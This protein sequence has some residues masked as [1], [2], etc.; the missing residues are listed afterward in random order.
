MWI[1]ELRYQDPR[2]Q[3]YL[4]SPSIVRLPGG[5]L[6]ASHD[7]F[8]RG[9][10]RNMEGEIHL[11]SVYRSDDDGRTW[12]NVTQISGAFWSTLFTTGDALYLIGATAKRGSVAIRRSE[13][14]GFSW[15][16]PADDKSGLISRAGRY[17]EP[18]NYHCAPV[19]VLE[20]DGRVYRAFEDDGMQDHGRDFLACGVS[21]PVDADLLDASNWTMSNKLKFEHD[22]APQY[23]EKATWLEGNV[24]ADRAGQLWNVLRFNGRRDDMPLANLAAFVRIDEDGA[25]LS[26]DY[27]TGVRELPGGATKFTIR[28]DEG[29]EHYWT[30][31]NDQ[32]A[33]PSRWRRNKLSLYSSPDLAT[34]TQRKLLLA[35]NLE[36]DPE[37][38]LR[39]TGFQ[40]VDWILDP[41]DD[42]TI[43]YL[44]RTAY[45]GA[46]NFH[47]SNR[48][49]F[50]RIRDFRSTLTA[51]R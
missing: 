21:A 1:S 44:S 49:T 42:G 32:R 47:D 20:H 10:P 28:W 14:G 29:S 38:S 13:D 46:N 18:P 15:T 33:D 51:T 36:C 43:L 9:A 40:Y 26:F 16:H 25:A 37:A 3:A 50:S 34:W 45:D 4:G 11:T 12:R 17:D 48:I 35:D 24:V 41:Q 39:N 6:V 31:A 19:P 7:Y 5:A 8:G 27:E 22:K 23:G 2:T 30:L